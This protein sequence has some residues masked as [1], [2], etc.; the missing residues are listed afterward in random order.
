MVSSMKNELIPEFCPYCGAKLDYDGVNVTCPNQLCPGIISAVVLDGI[1]VLGIK[2]IGPAMVKDM[3]DSGLMDISDLFDKE[4]R[5]TMESNG[6][7]VTENVKKAYAAIDSIKSIDLY[8]VLM[9]MKFDGMGKVTAKQVAN[10]IAGIEYSFFGLDSATVDG[11]KEEGSVERNYVLKYAD[12]FAR[13]GVEVVFPKQVSSTSIEYEMTGSPKPTFS[14][15]EEFEKFA[16]EHGYRHGKISSAKLL[17]TDSYSSTS[18]KM[19]AAKKKNIDIITYEE[20]K[21][22]YGR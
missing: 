4:F 15:K 21:E 11:F 1:S 19:T 9:L 10:C 14:T 20:F 18:S 22:K 5:R 13:L 16:S 7:K 17:V 3:V 8:K 12:K 2:G 6:L